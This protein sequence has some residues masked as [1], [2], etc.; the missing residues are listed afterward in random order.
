LCGYKGYFNPD[1]VQRPTGIVSG[2]GQ[3]HQKVTTS[4]PEAQAYYD[5]GLTYLHNYVWVEA[6]RSFHQALR[7]DPKL[8]MAEVGLALSYTGMEARE[9]VAKHLARAKELAIG[10]S[11]KEQRIIA[12]RALQW[13]AITAPVAERQA[14]HLAYKKALDDLIAQDP[15]D[16]EIWIMRGNAEEPGVWG[17]GQVGGVGAIAYYETALRRNPDHLGAHHYLVHS[18]ENIGRH[19]D[20]AKHG[21]VYAK[22][23]PAVAHAQHMVGH[24]LP[25]LN[26]W[27]EAIAQFEKAN[28]IE[29]D[30]F[31]REKILPQEDWHH[32]HNLHLLGMIY[33]HEGKVAEAEKILKRAFD[34]PV[35][36]PFIEASWHAPYIE[37]LLNQGRFDEALKAA[38]LLASKES[39]AA[40][41][42]GEALVGEA[43]LM[44]GNVDEARAAAE[45]SSSYLKTARARIAGHPLEIFIL[46][47]VESFLIQLNG[48]L[49]LRSPD[50]SAGEKALIAMADGILATPLFDAWGEGLF[51]ME[52]VGRDAL[53][54]GRRELADQIRSRMIKLDLSYKPRF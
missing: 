26:R 10:I 14:K 49:A 1:L 21:E 5:Q 28:K 42:V 8:A 4:I 19:A 11:Q 46:R 27:Q 23:A 50:P 9:E 24:V 13:E 45:R 32:V 15:S 25:R 39:A 47:R 30:Y 6:A 31:L 48:Q 51:K 36:N 12:A 29:E 16:T 40:K 20:A 7:L 54:S 41:T 33:L 52:R 2:I 18:Y 43:L 38:Q 37:F 34:T 17:R 53:K 22:S 35:Y 3:V 44:L